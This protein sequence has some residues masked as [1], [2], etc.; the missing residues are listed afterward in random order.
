MRSRFLRVILIQAVLLAVVILLPVRIYATPDVFLAVVASGIIAVA[1]MGLGLLGFEIGFDKSNTI[2]L[3]TVFGSMA[4]RMVLIMMA[5]TILLLE[6]FH[7]LA[8]SLSL[9]CFYLLTL[10]AEI[11]YALRVLAG[12]K[13]ML[14]REDEEHDGDENVAFA[15][16][17]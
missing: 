12:R 1:N 15:Q 2:F 9:M 16:S 14:P 5:L 13:V 8:L 11:M 3:S 4:F 7:A 10:V 17:L 6:G